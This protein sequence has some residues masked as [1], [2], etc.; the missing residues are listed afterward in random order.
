MQMNIS[1]AA[2]LAALFAAISPGLAQ[3]SSTGQS[4]LSYPSLGRRSTTINHDNA[5]PSTNGRAA[6]AGESIHGAGGGTDVFAASEWVDSEFLGET[7]QAAS[8]ELELGR[9]AGEKSQR[10]D[11][12]NLA[13]SVVMGHTRMTAALKSLAESHNL[14]VSIATPP[15]RRARIDAITKLQGAEFDRAYLQHLVSYY[16]REL[17]RFAFEEKNGSITELTALAGRVSPRLQHHLRAAKECLRTPAAAAQ[18]RK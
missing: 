17:G 5:T 15:R 4:D 18:P 7:L 11:V 12:K 3:Q 6:S 9:L 8:V 16:E 1:A 14:A 2:G 13:R 10:E